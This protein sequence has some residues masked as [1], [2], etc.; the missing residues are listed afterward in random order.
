MLRAALLLAGILAVVAGSPGGVH[1][2]RHDAVVHELKRLA[3]ADHFIYHLDLEAA[4]RALAAALGEAHGEPVAGRYEC[5][6]ENCP[7]DGVY[8]V[9]SAVD[10]FVAQATCYWQDAA[11]SLEMRKSA[12]ANSVW[13]VR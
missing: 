4:T 3:R 12:G 1:E 8:Y 6:G 13:E 9:V 7:A 5:Q 10:A 2:R 11:V